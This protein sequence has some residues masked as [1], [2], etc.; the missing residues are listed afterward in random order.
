M[1]ATGLLNTGGNLGGLF[2]TPVV[3][4]LSGQHQW[5]AAFVIGTVLA[6]LSAILWLGV[7]PTRHLDSTEQS[8][9]SSES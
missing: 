4:W 8:G 1:S 7:D 5:T 3:A 9:S 6:M 2:A